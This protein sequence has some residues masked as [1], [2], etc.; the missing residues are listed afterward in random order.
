MADN[1]L[2]IAIVG[3]GQV[4]SAFAYKL[5]TAGHDVTAI[6]RPNSKRLQKLRSD[7]CVVLDGSDRVSVT[8]ADT[9]DEQIPYDLVVVTVP[10]HRIDALVTALKRSRARAVH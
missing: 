5:A 3:T 2:S 4:G 8:I 6:A 10:A 1:R 9:L 7:G